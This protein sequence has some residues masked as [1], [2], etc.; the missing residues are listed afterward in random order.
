VVVHGFAVLRTTVMLPEGIDPGEGINMDGIAR[1]D[2]ITA[3][4]FKVALI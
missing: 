4:T 2:A 1:T 3:H